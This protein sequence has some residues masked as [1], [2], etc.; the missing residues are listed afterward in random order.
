[1]NCE[2]S[3]HVYPLP[4]YVESFLTFTGVIFLVCLLL[5]IFQAYGLRLRH[6]IAACYYPKRERARA[7]WLYN[8]ILKNRGGFLKFARRQMKR[9]NGQLQEEEKIS[10]RSRIMSQ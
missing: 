5:T 10:I 7:V 3:C 9:K 8:H 4:V 1:M 6:V 2:I